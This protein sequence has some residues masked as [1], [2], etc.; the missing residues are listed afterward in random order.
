MD[1]G[2]GEMLAGKRM[3]FSNEDLGKTIEE[4]RAVFES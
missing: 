3:Q 2:G 4:V 1:K